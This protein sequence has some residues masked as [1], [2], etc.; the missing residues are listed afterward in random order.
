MIYPSHTQVLL[1]L[2]LSLLLL[3]LLLLLTLHVVL[4]LFYCLV[5]FSCV[6]LFCFLFKVLSLKKK[7][8]K[9]RKENRRVQ[10]IKSS[11]N[12]PSLK[13]TRNLW[14]ITTP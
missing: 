8:K 11:L 7:R 6:V 5:I 12:K 10:K 2:S 14:R 3:L 13:K 4:K 9:A 1:L